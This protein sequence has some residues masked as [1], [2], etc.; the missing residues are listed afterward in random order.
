[1][2]SRMAHLAKKGG[3]AQRSISPSNSSLNAKSGLVARQ[4]STLVVAR[5]L[6]TEIDGG[7][8]SG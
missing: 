4:T 8:V 7:V 6:I 3:K 1:M 2:A 5:L